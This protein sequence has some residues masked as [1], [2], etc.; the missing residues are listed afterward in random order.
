VLGYVFG[1]IASNQ[2][3]DGTTVASSLIFEV[4]YVPG[5]V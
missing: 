2:P 1:G 4:R 5:S 3:N